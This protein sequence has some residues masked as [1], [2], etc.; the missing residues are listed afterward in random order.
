MYDPILRRWQDQ[1]R[2]AWNQDLGF[3][4]PFLQLTI[5]AAGPLG[6]VKAHPHV[7]L[8]LA[9]SLANATLSV[10]FDLCG[11]AFIGPC[12]LCALGGP[13]LCADDI[14]YLT[15]SFPMYPLL[16]PPVDLESDCK[17]L[18]GGGAPTLANAHDSTHAQVHVEAGGSINIGSSGTLLVGGTAES[19]EKEARI[20]ELEAEVER[21]TA[22]LGRCRA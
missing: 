2:A 16:L 14:P 12:P 9:G 18:A 10:G 3:K 17:L 21:L 8:Q 5:P 20:A 6:G 11:Q 13:V 1:G 4:A 19:A 22:E 15:E 7:L